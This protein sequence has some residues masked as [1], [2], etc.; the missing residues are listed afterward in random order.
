M[1]RIAAAFAAIIGTASAAAAQD[2]S[3]IVIAPTINAPV[4][5]IQAP[6]GRRDVNGRCLDS[7]CSSS[8]VVVTG[9]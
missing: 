7:Y 9:R 8:S 6:E 3:I 1:T 2:S 4:I 5:V